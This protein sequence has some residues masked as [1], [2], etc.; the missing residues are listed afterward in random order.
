MSIYSFTTKNTFCVNLPNP[1]CVVGWAP[2]DVLAFW[3]KLV[4]ADCVEGNKDVPLV[5][6]NPDVEGLPKPVAGLPN[7]C[8]G[9]PNGLAFAVEVVPNPDH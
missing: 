4:G 5:W 9:C 7:S 6:P 8:W 1:L 2:K 3:N